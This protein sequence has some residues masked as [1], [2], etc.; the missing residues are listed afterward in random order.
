MT[1]W[2]FNKASRNHISL[3]LS[4]ILHKILYIHIVLPHKNHGVTKKKKLSIRQRNFLLNGWSC[5]KVTPKTIE[6]TT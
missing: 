4:K 3:Y 5:I 2:L 6:T 1:P